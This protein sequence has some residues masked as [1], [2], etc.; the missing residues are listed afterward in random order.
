MPQIYDEPKRTSV[1]E[2]SELSISAFLKHKV[3]AL[4]TKKPT[5]KTDFEENVDVLEQ[6]SLLRE[7][8]PKTKFPSF[9]FVVCVLLLL[10]SLFSNRAK[11]QEFTGDTKL[12]CE[13]ILC[14]SSPTRPGECAAS[15]ARYFSFSGKDVGTKRRNFLELCPS[16]NVT[17]EM[18]QLTNVLLASADQCGV[19]QLNAQHT[20]IYRTRRLPDGETI[21]EFMVVINN[22]MPANCAAYYAN[23]IIA[24]NVSEKPYFIGT[25]EFNGYWVTAQVYEAALA[26]YNGKLSVYK[27]ESARRW[28]PVQDGSYGNGR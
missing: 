10:F 24:G 15:I 16:A 2:L 4:F 6:K 28:Q 19:N 3:R 20:K 14:F 21:R 13:A 26:D 17:P 22:Q 1:N 23:P 7:P 27:V 25:P 12:A 9:T 11:S 8:K 5:I 18:Q